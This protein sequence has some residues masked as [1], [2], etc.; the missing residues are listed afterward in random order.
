M[1]V[2]PHKH[3]MVVLPM[4]VRVAKISKDAL[5]THMHFLVRLLL[6][7]AGSTPR[8]VGLTETEDEVS[9]MLPDSPDLMDV[10][11]DMVRLLAPARLW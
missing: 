7:E 9:L 11:G 5:Q 6:L 1:A 4:A 2:R 8:L 3:P 10:V